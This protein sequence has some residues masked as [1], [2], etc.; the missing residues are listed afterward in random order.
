MVAVLVAMRT[1][2]S[3]EPIV[4]IVVGPNSGAK[5]AMVQG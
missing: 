5:T 1:S 2:L 4:N 3:M